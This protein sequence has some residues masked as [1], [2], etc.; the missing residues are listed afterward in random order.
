VPLAECL[1]NVEA[2]HCTNK[3]V[4]M[5]IPQIMYNKSCWFTHQYP[6]QRLLLCGWIAVLCVSHS[7]IFII[8]L[9]SE[10]LL[11]P[12]PA[13]KGDVNTRNL[14]P[15]QRGLC[16]A[17]WVATPQHRDANICMASFSFFFPPLVII[18][19]LKVK[20]MCMRL[21]A[22]WKSNHL[23]KEAQKDYLVLRQF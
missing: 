7:V 15:C 6:Y 18:S 19:R 17:E 14:Y 5:N 3:N 9:F 4:K 20:S 23:N 11:F 21:S 1:L 8:K 16:Q 22:S 10:P 12:G 13:E 2:C